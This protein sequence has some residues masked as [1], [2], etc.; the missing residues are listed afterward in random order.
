MKYKVKVEYG[1]DR[2]VKFSIDGQLVDGSIQ[3]YSFSSLVEDIR[4]RCGSLRHQF[5]RIRYKDE[6]G[7]YVN[8]IEDDIENFNDMFVRAPSEGEGTALCRKI[9][10]RVAELDSPVVQPMD[11]TVKRRKLHELPSNVTQQNTTGG[12]L[13]PRSLEPS[14]NTANSALDHVKNELTENLQIKKALLSSAE[15]ELLKVTHENESLTPLSAIRGR[16]CGNCHKSGHTKP[17]CLSSPCSS[18]EVCGVR[19]KHPELKQKIAELQK[20][21]KRLQ[22]EF[23]DAQSKLMAFS[24]SRTRASTSF[25]AIMRPR[26]KVRNLIKYS[27]RVQLDRDLLIL[28]KALN[29]KVP[30]FDASQDWKLPVLIEQYRNRNIDNYL[31]RGCSSSSST[32]VSID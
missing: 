5:L 4:K 23:N 31:N 1:K 17:K 28:E 9:L 11:C 22:Q 26:L 25:F 2:F 32:R 18:H 16:L 19:D 8:L 3:N 12:K 14:F 21:I 13:C 10:L 24:E 27:V 30:D 20:E 7:D 29:G 15:D 6:D